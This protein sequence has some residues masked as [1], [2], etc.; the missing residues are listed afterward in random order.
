MSSYYGE[1]DEE[2][3]AIGRLLLAA[4]LAGLA[5]GVLAASALSAAAIGAGLLADRL[6]R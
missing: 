4:A 6:R 5:A 2:L 3:P 1:L